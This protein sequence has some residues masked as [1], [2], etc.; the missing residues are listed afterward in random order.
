MTSYLNFIVSFFLAHSLLAVSASERISSKV[1]E[2]CNTNKKEE[3]DS[4]WVLKKQAYSVR[5]IKH[6][7]RYSILKADGTTLLQAH[8]TSGLVLLNSNVVDSR[9][10]SQ[11]DNEAKFTVINDIGI[12]AEVKLYLYDNY[13]K[14]SVNYIG[15]TAIS[16]SIIARTQGLAPAYGL[17]DNAAFHEPYT[18]EVSG[19][20]DRQF[21]AKSILAKEARLISNF[22]IFP[23]Q[24]LACI[25]IEPDKKI[26]KISNTDLS[27]GSFNVTSMPTMYYFI[28]AVKQIYADYLQ[29]RNKEGYKVYLP[30]YPWFGVGWEAWGALE[31]NT[32]FKTVSDDVDHYLAAGFPLSWMVVGS[33]FWPNAEPKYA[34]TTSFGAWDPVKYPDPKGFIDYFHKKGLKFMLGLRIAF[35]PNGLYTNEGVANGYFLKKDGI[36]YLFKTAFPKT[37]CYFLDAANPAAVSWY[38]NLC[39]KWEAAGVDGFKEDLY[40]Y[41]TRDFKDNKLDAVNR[42]L[43][44]RGVYVMG[45]NGYIGSPM[46]LHRY[47]DFNYPEDQDR[48]PVNGLSFAYS[49][50]PYVYPDVVGGTRLGKL[51]GKQ[52]DKAK[53]YLMRAAQYAAVNPSMSFGYGPWNF[54]DEQVL[55]VCRSAA[56]LHERLHPYIYSAAVKTYLTGFPYSMT[57]LPLAYPTDSATYY[58]ENAKVRG[59]QWLLGEALLAAPMYGDDYE[60]STTRDIYLPAG[61]WI[62]Y[63]SGKMY[64]GQTLLTNFKIPVD[65]TPL[66]VGGTGLVIEKIDGKLIARVYPVGFK[67]ETVFYDQ[68]GKT[69]SVFSIEIHNDRSPI[70]TNTSTGKRVTPH[71][72][73]HAHEFVFVPGH[74]YKIE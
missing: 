22:V 54:N 40:G 47:N 27:Q 36:P 17:A 2:L 63:D 6:G 59:Y 18:T 29:V 61:K 70:I 45:R 50:F 13:F 53:I 21:G 44:N 66:F 58:R 68:D 28:G 41:E 72:R 24:G 60:E 8:N 12:R 38:D 35:I 34:A 62:D 37:D 32:N 49:G 4:V 19:F 55:A 25:N 43:M 74:N 30:K 3:P 67:G 5:I 48:G 51:E 20:T 39:K 71:H 46:D 14:I 64:E 31:W 42:A 57:P 16:G 11:S 56:Q 9:L 65:K 15:A 52:K 7:F 23:K 26:I 69:K 10:I 1:D 33:G 73:K